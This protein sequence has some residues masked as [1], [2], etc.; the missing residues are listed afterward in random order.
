MF[1]I[2]YLFNT[3]MLG[4]FIFQSNEMVESKNNENLKSFFKHGLYMVCLNLP[5]ILIYEIKEWFILN[6]IIYMTHILIDYSKVKLEKKDKGVKN[7]VILFIF[8]QFLHIIIILLLTKLIKFK[9][10]AFGKLIIDFL[11]VS[12]LNI[13]IINKY[14]WLSFILINVVFLGGKLIGII[15]K[16]LKPK[17]YENIIKHGIIIG[18]LERMLIFLLLLFGNY[19]GITVIIGLKTLTRF[20]GIGEDKEFAEYYLIGTL[21]SIVICLIGFGVYLFPRLM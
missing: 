20:K 4:D 21:L 2:L 6:M 14:L 8:D 19:T 11:G 7:K 12:N 16:D 10:S 5:L 1:I 17:N 9:I 15:L 18:Q 3:H 13:Q